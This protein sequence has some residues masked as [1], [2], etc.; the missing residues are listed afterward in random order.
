LKLHP[1]KC[2]LFKRRILF[3]GQYVSPDGVGANAAKTKAVLEWK[4]PTSQTQL[5]SFL[6]LCNYLKNFITHYADLAEPL[7]RLTEKNRTFR[8]T[9]EAERSFQAL[10]TALTVPPVLGF[11]RIG[12]VTTTVIDPDLKKNEYLFILDCDASMTAVGSILSQV[13]DGQERVIAY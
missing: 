7:Y 4:T 2:T 8:W 5:R 12:T 1:K 11:P 6:G 9:E 3:L 10:K 13:Q